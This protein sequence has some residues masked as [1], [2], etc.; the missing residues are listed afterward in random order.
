MKKMMILAVMMVMTISA[1]AMSYNA[2]KHEALFLSDKM[3]YELN[4]TAAQY[5]AVYEINLDYLM[6][7][8]GHGD[9]FGI[10]WD[11]RNADLRFVLNSWQFDKYMSL[12]HFYRPVAWKAGSWTFAVYSHYNRG[13]FYNAHPKVFVTYRGGNNHKHDRF[14]ADRHMSKPAVHHKAPAP[15]PHNGKHDMAHND[16]RGSDR[17][18]AM[19]TS[20]GNGGHFSGRR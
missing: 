7:L 14:Y 20:R 16:R 18:M 5:E 6:S 4:L 10:W 12:A 1:N 19:N 2:A 9:V 13:H 3:A 15:A 8:N 11:R 17:H